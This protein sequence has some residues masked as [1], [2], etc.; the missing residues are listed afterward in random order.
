M[1][2]TNSTETNYVS[3]DASWFEP[4]AVDVCRKPYA[5]LN[6]PFPPPLR[7]ARY[8]RQSLHNI[9]GM[10]SSTI[11]TELNITFQNQQHIHCIIDLCIGNSFSCLFVSAD[12]LSNEIHSMRKEIVFLFNSKLNN[13]KKHLLFCFIKTRVWQN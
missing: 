3:K 6:C 12:S 4:C 8:K 2:H 13:K 10:V 1:L 11:G 9:Y 7:K 5:G